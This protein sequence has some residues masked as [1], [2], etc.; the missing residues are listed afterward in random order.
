MI[1]R[2]LILALASLLLVSCSKTETKRYEI[3]IEVDTPQ[4]VRS[5]SAIRQITHRVPPTFPSIGESKARLE[6][7]GE[8]VVVDLGSGQAI[9]GLLVGRDR[10]RQQADWGIWALLEE[11]N[12]SGERPIDLWPNSPTTS[13]PRFDDFVPM[14]VTFT[15]ESVPESVTEVDPQ[16]LAA[17]FGTEV[18]LKRVS[19]RKTNKRPTDGIE[20]RLPWLDNFPERRLDRDFKGSS[21]PTLPQWLWIRDFKR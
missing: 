6:L 1:Y 21:S 4:G 7:S 14:L 18:S 19:V 8:A 3:S 16:D 17:S 11:R 20:E 13:T 5:G 9:Y 2:A 12:S 10:S 15:D